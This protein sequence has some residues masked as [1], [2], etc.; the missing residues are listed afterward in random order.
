VR[1]QVRAPP[2]PVAAATG[3]GAG[4][5]AVIGTGVGAAAAGAIDDVARHDED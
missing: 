5:D 3:Y 4:K 2:Q 1:R